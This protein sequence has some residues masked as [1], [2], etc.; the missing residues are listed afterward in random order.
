M[1]KI[2]VI[3]RW[4]WLISRVFVLFSGEFKLVER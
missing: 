2:G 1:V 4:G 3:R